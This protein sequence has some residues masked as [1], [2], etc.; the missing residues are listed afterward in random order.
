MRSARNAYDLG[1][2]RVPGDTR[3]LNDEGQTHL[4]L[5][6]VRLAAGSAPFV[7]YDEAG[8]VGGD[9]GLRAVA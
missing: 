7:G 2:P 8:L 6:A 9:D 5:T 3:V 4:C 1:L